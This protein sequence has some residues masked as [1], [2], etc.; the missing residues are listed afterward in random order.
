MFDNSNGEKILGIIIGD[1]L[2][3]KSHIISQKI[4][5]STP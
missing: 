5:F 2:T 1:E 3:F 4:L